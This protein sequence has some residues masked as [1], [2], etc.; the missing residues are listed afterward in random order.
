MSTFYIVRNKH[1]GEWLPAS[2]QRNSTAARLCRDHPPRL[3]KTPGGAKNALNWWSYG[4]FHMNRG[5]YGDDWDLDVVRCKD[6]KKE[7]MEV[8]EVTL[9]VNEVSNNV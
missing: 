1:T 6:R 3:F 4:V 2:K 9:T 8:V 5:A 7:D